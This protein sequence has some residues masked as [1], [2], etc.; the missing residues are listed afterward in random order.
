MEEFVTLHENHVE[1]VTSL[2][3]N[4]HVRP[5]SSGVEVPLNRTSTSFLVRITRA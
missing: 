5:L 1:V 4:L 3:V 2:E